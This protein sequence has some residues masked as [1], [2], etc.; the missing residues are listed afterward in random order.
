LFDLFT[1]G[2]GE[3]RRS[4]GGLGIGL[5]LVKQLV[6]LHQGRVTASSEG[7]GRGSE[8]TVH[9]PLA[10]DQSAPEY[11]E[12]ESSDKPPASK[13]LRILVVDDSEDAA[14]TLAT[15]LELAGYELH[16][17]H[18]GEQALAAAEACRPD[19]ILLDIGLPKLSGNDVCRRLR[20]QDWG[21]EMTVIALTGWGQEKDRRRTAEAGFD[22]HLVKPADP[23]ALLK[24]LDGLAA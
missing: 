21:R 1:Q 9:L 3:R 17:A 10:A 16:L 7:P 24:L 23:A 11:P 12:P 13:G 18:D 5:S 20:Q 4:G 8:F 6:E 19:V 22:H 2:E 15:L 14:L